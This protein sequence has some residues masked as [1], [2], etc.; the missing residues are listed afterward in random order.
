MVTLHVEK[1]KQGDKR[2]QS[3]YW[4]LHTTNSPAVCD[5]H[6]YGFHPLPGPSMG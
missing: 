5:A 1:G 2:K 4:S 3:L 6:E